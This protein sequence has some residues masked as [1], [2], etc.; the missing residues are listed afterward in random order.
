MQNASSKLLILALT[1]PLALCASPTLQAQTFVAPLQVTGPSPTDFEF[2]AD[3]TLIAKGATGTGSLLSTDQGAGTRLLW[4]PNLAAFR[5][6]TVSGTQWNLSLIG[7]YSLALGIN[8]TAS[9]DGSTA[10]GLGSSAS[11]YGSV[12]M[13]DSPTASGY[14][15]FA[16]GRYSIA[17]G[18]LSVAGGY[19]S[20][21][22]GGGSLAFGNQ[23]SAA[24]TN[25]TA[26][27]D[28]T[29]AASYDSFAVGSFNVGGGNATSWVATDPLFEVGNGT[30]QQ[31]S[32]A[33]VI[34]KNGSAA[35]QGVVSVAAGGDIPMYTGN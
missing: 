14:A 21:A 25:S 3:G 35:F 13:G 20:T 24:G 23:A 26:I 1:L 19:V 31:K 30:G 4:F 2:R 8:T 28:C 17:A 33:L 15:S 6:G 16:I 5:A 10:F 29:T 32:D 7:R 9:G 11:G 22:T 34:Y 27:G 18:S 12:A